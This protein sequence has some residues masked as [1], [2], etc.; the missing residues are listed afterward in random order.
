MSERKQRFEVGTSVRIEAATSSGDISARPGDAGEVLVTVKGPGADDYQI[1]QH[2][3][4]IRVLPENTGVLRRFST[5]EVFLTT[6]SGASLHLT[7]ASGDISVQ[8]PVADVEA[9]AASG[10]IRVGSVSGAGRLRTASGDIQVDSVGGRLFVDSASGDVRVGRVGSDMAAHSA[11]GDIS[12]DYAAGAVDVNT[13]SGDLQVLHVDGDDV[14]VK[15]VSGDVRL[16]IPPR[17]TLEVEVQTLSGDVR[18]RLPTG[19]GSPP[20]KRVVLTVKTLSGDITLHGI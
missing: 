15:T 4:T 2:G 18:N 1:T 6:P 11:S 10:E 12:V 9:T 20:E 5:A 3:D 7:A 16:G 14:R 8:A 19:D 13:A 17:R